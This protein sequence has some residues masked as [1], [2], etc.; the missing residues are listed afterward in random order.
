[1]LLAMLGGLLLNLMPCVFPV[2]SLKLA[3]LARMSGDS[4][5]KMLQ[6]G[7]CY[8][9]GIATT[10]ALLTTIVLGLRAA[11]EQ[12]GWGFQFQ[13]PWFI[14]FLACVVTVFAANLLG[15]FELSTPQLHDAT[16]KLPDHPL[17]HSFAEGLLCVLLATPCSAPF[18]GTA[19]GFALSADAL[20]ILL[21]FQAL[22]LGLASP[23][24][25][26]TAAPAWRRLLPKPGPWFDTL[27]QALAFSMLATAC[28]L[29]WIFGQTQGV[30]GMTRL[31][32]TLVILAAASWL[33]G[34]SQLATPKKKIALIST[35]LIISSTSLLFILDV[36]REPSAQDIAATTTHT[37]G[38]ITWQPFSPEAVQ[39][40]LDAGHPVFLDFTADWCITCKVNERGPLSSQ[41]V[42]DAFAQ[43]NVVT[44]KADWTRRDEQIRAI[45]A[46]FGRGGVPM[47]LMYSPKRPEQPQLLPELLTPS[48]LLQATRDATSSP[49]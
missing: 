1:M 4:P 28:W 17:W 20:T 41:A 9:A 10:M 46:S 21:I 48:I 2:L 8:T 31:L 34:L 32:I 45:L 30:D 15:A 37:S 24:L 16:N 12:V 44:L 7:L 5:K 47:Y 11:G 35:A 40:A 42:I 33:W 26:L 13:N 43:A 38:G 39:T 29:L 36:Q 14:V 3:S 27:R 19:V 49:K 18:M 23:F 22:G 6:H 25:I